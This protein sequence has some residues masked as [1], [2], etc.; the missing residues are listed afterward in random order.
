MGNPDDPKW[1][2]TL[3]Y[4]EM[5]DRETASDSTP[6][7]QWVFC[8]LS[9]PRQRLHRSKM[10]PE[11]APALR[12]SRL[13]LFGGNPENIDAL[14]PPD[15]PLGGGSLPDKGLHSPILLPPVIG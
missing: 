8:N 11:P 10:S 1:E 7:R 5:A 9:G 3:A 4:R 13:P 12:L 6:Y 15:H 14:V 2:K